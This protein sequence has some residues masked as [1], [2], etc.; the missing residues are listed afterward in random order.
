MLGSEYNWLISLNYNLDGVPKV[1]LAKSGLFTLCI[2]IFCFLCITLQAGA[3]PGSIPVEA[4][5]DLI[6]IT[7]AHKVP[8]GLMSSP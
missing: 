2:A 6:Q 5:R 8:A 3:S 7:S 1:S 4:Q